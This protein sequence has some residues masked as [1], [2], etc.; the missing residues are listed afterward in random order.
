MPMPSEMGYSFTPTEIQDIKDHFDGILTIINNKKVVQLTAKERQAAQSA[1]ETRF[2]Y[3]Q[4]AIKNLAPAFPNLQPNFLKLSD[5]E[6]DYDTSFQLRSLIGLRDE[7]N[8]RM[9]DFSMASEH[10]AYQY[11]RKFYNNAKEAQDVNTPGADT[12]VDALAPL[13]EGQGKQPD[14]VENP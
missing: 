11:M 3:I 13:F 2:P 4:N 8:D 12:V 10:F 9:I 6:I 7:V 5:A 14:V 1:S